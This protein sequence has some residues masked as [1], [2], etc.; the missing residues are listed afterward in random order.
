MKATG[1]M[2][3]RAAFPALVRGL[4]AMGVCALWSGASVGQPVL[5]ARVNGTGITLELLDRQFEELL[6]ERKLQIAR[7]NNPAKAKS[8]K[9]EALDKLIRIELLWQEAK[10]A[11]LVATDA[12]V[13][14]AVAEARGRFRTHDAFVRRIESSGFSEAGY[15][16]HTRK[17][18]SG[19]RYAQRIV[20]RDVRVTDKDVEE[21]Y[22][23]N[24]RLFR[25]EEQVKVRQILVIVPGDAKPAQKEQ[26]RRR[27]DEL[28]ARV[29][30]GEDFEAL[31]RRHSDDATRQWG[32]ELDPFAR[33]QMP[34]PFEDAAFA[35]AA[36]GA[37]SG[38][39]ETATGWHI[40]K[41]E[42]RI[43]AVSVPLGD[44][45]E[46][47][48]EYLRQTRGMEAIDKEVEQLRALGKVELLTPL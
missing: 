45:R 8:I 34:K 17:L 4:L 15:R 46:R 42:Q 28:R 9:R 27:I 38:I 11:G 6:R 22:A 14:R 7:M 2:S 23:I 31:A 13:D 18:L 26:A 35:L 41:L 10:S 39:I 44:A 32:G 21:F 5:A 3:V 12:E 30:S 48:R 47:I 33:G 16:E 29:R 24:P 40:V 1:S 19:E 20:E 43:P 37:V 36:P 25:R